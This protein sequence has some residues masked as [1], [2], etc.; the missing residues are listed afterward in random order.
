MYTFIFTY[1][2]LSD[3]VERFRLNGPPSSSV[4][5]AK[6]STC[7]TRISP[8]ISCQHGK[9]TDLSEGLWSEN[10]ARKTDARFNF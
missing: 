2:Y 5:Q 6:A 9:I 4:E 3:C 1:V 8:S 7:F 10:Q